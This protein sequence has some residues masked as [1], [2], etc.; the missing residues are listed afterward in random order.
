MKPVT[1]TGTQISGSRKQ[2]RPMNY[3]A[4]FPT[5]ILSNNSL[6]TSWYAHA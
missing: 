2:L 3:R 6:G 5:A 1:T 4:I